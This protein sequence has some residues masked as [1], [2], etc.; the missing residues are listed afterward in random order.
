MPVPEEEPVQA[1][2]IWPEQHAAY[3][4]FV[5]VRE[6]EGRRQFREFVMAAN[7]A[8]EACAVELSL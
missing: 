4:S 3:S 5:T 1:P 8:A 6:E 7:D 2:P